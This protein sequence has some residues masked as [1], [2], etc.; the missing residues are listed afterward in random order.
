MT[1]YEIL[2]LLAGIAGA[3]LTICKLVSPIVKK[4]KKCI[5]FFTD[6]R[7]EITQIK[8]EQQNCKKDLSELHAKNDYIQQK[9]EKVEEHTTENY[10][11][12]LRIIIMSEEMPLGER[13][14]AG[15]KYVALNGNGEIKQKY[16]HLMERYAEEER[17]KE[18]NGS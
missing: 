14:Q 12:E 8:K 3:I 1:P 2:L 11:N 15:E 7:N 6:M 18:E 5:S 9:V 13:L 10:M 17:M 4:V 16:K